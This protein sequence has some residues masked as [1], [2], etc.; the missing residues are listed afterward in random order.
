MSRISRRQ[1]FGTSLAMGTTLGLPLVEASAGG[2]PARGKLKVVFAGGHPDDPEQYA[3]GTMARY[4][5]LGH[6]VVALYL[7]RGEAGIPGKS[8]REA[9]AQRTAEAESACK[10]LKARARFV[11]QI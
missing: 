4:S 5:D 3:G 10:I 1:I 11:G 6:D 9:A 7:T 8:H 2:R